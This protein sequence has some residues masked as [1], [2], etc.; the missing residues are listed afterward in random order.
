MAKDNDGIQGVWRTISGR[1]VFIKDGQDLATAMRESGKFN[2]LKTKKGVKEIKYV[3]QDNKIHKMNSYE[4]PKNRDEYHGFLKREYGTYK[5]EEINVDAKKLRNDFYEYE[6]SA[7]M[8]ETM[9]RRQAIIER[10][11]KETEDLS[12]YDRYNLAVSKLENEDY[13]SA[14]ERQYWAGEKE[15]YEKSAKTKENEAEKY[16]SKL[17]NNEVYEDA[18]KLRDE[19]K[20]YNLKNEIDKRLNRID[21]ANRKGEGYANK[22]TDELREIL[23]NNKEFHYAGEELYSDDPNRFGDK[24]RKYNE[25]MNPTKDDFNEWK[26]KN[27]VDYKDYTDYVERRTTL[28]PDNYE[29]YEEYDKALR[30]QY[31][32]HREN[33]AVE[34]ISEKSGNDYLPKEKKVET[35]GTSN[36]KEVSDNIQAHILNY[37]DNPVDFMEQMDAMDWLPTRWHAGQ[38]LAKGGSYL[39]YNGDMADFL[40]SLNINPKGKKFSEDKSF[41]MYTSLIGRESERLY[42]RLEKLFDQYKKEHK[43]SNATLDDFRKWFK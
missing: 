31:L 8:N 10:L 41:Q 2:N 3:G 43:N 1:R 25:K 29:S 12:D 17:S 38:E 39:I 23:K 24:M 27:N 32:Q 13:S 16:Y 14:T 35:A 42:N 28:N 4:Y 26:E 22:P 20:D 30:K 9:D 21:R 34:K 5:E 7:K 33:K 37:Y 18:W 40:D 11:D 19:T 15:R 36:R 6:K